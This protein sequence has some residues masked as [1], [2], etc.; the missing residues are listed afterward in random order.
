MRSFFTV[1]Q[2]NITPL[3]VESL[4][5]KEIYNIYR[6]GEDKGLLLEIDLLRLDL[7]EI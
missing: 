4:V 6:G 2:P 7:R 5:T 3:F 1:E